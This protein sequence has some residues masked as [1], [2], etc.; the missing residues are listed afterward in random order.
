M[1]SAMDLDASLD[2]IIKKKRPQQQKKINKPQLKNNN[3]QNKNTNNNNKNKKK[4]TGKQAQVQQKTTKNTGIL[5]R[6]GR[7]GVQ[8]QSKTTM[9]QGNRPALTTPLRT[10]KGRNTILA[11]ALSK[12]A[13]KASTPSADPSSIVITKQISS[14][15]NSSDELQR[16]SGSF[17]FQQR[18]QS[19]FSIAQQQ[20]SFRQEPSF[21]I[22]GVS[23]SPSSSS[24]GISIRG[25]SGPA[26]V[27]IS[28]LDRE[29]NADD[30]KTACSQFGEVIGCEVFY[31]RNGRSVGEAEV[32]FASKASALDCIAKLDNEEADGQIIRVT[33]RER[34]N[35]YLRQ[36]D[37]RPIIASTV[38]YPSTGKMYA[39]QMNT[40]SRYGVQNGRRY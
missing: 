25:E 16:S 17:A 22:R 40:T 27:L 3:K 29:A 14:S 34:P 20:P 37:T 1:S 10:N 21:S 5:S 11:K 28:N 36:S 4:N 8:Q 30:I 13:T 24:S 23:R 33:L 9:K 32:E 26:S 19:P 12:T 15:R 38:A 35:K 6:L 7:I 39:D 18:Y 2:D 31:D